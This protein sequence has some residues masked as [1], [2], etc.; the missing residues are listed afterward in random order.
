M[1]DLFDSESLFGETASSWSMPLAQPPGGAT[2]PMPVEAKEERAKEQA[3]ARARIKT[4]LDELTRKQHC[5]EPQA[6]AKAPPPSAS[7]GAGRLLQRHPQT[8]FEVAQPTTPEELAKARQASEGLE[9]EAAACKAVSPSKRQKVLAPL[10]TM[11]GAE[12]VDGHT[13]SISPAVLAEQNA[14]GA[15]Q[16]TSEEQW[17]AGA[18]SFT[19]GSLSLKGPGKVVWSKLNNMKAPLQR[20]RR[21]QRCVD[22]AAAGDATPTTPNNEPK[23]ITVDTLFRLGWVL[24]GVQRL[25]PAETASDSD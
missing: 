12:M 23:Q 21:H 14:G 5:V 18:D 2:S 22:Q 19:T 25:P 4:G 3:A 24:P 8:A 10:A 16:P 11:S 17:Q 9:Q 6:A 13:V 20:H 7:S 1:T 15:T